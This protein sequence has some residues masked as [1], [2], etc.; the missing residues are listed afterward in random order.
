MQGDMNQGDANQGDQGLSAVFQ[1]LKGALRARGMTYRDV[2]AQIGLSESAIKKIFS[3]EDC[4]LA[5]LSE[6]AA[7]AGMPLSELFSLSSRPAFERVRLTEAQ[8]RGL[9]ERPDAFAMYWKLAVERLTLAEIKRR[10]GLS[11]ARTWTLL[12]RL[13]DLGL[14]VLEPGD[15]VRLVHAGLIRWVEEGPLLTHLYRTWPQRLIDDALGAPHDPEQAHGA[16]FRLHEISARPDTADELKRQI[17]GLLDD[18]LR[19]ARYEQ[20]TTRPDDRDPVRVLLA[21]APGG[22]VPDLS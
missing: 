2:G 20:A 19:R 16:L 21:I 1:T 5:R 17:A 8:Q 12:S 9:L 4:S 15:R 22:F 11:D 10:H 18:F 3:N 6:I 13:D 14:V 7:A